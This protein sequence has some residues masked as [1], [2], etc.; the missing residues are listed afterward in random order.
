MHLGFRAT[1]EC[2]RRV[3]DGPRGGPPREE[4]MMVLGV[5]SLAMLRS[6]TAL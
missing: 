3:E 6:W 2:D 1:H 5:L 4:A